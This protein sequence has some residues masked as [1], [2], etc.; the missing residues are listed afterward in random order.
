MKKIVFVF[1]LIVSLSVFAEKAAKSTTTTKRIEVQGHRGAR[2]K[3][4]ENSLPAFEYALGLGV[5]VLELDLGVSKDKKLVLAHDPYIN[6]EQ[7]LDKD[8]NKIKEKVLLYSLNLSEIKT[9]KCGTLPHPRFPEQKKMEVGYIT[10]DEVFEL[11]GASTLPSAKTVR[12][13]IETKLVPGY[14]QITPEPK[15][16]AELVITTLKKYKML[17]RTVLQSF[18]HRT[19]VEAR[20]LEPKIGLSPLL[21]NNFIDLNAMAKNLKAKIVSPNQMWINKEAVIRA[22]KEGIHVIPWT[23]NNKT[24]WERLIDL[25][26][27]GII[28]DYPEELIAFL[29]TKNLR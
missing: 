19:L 21:E 3:F 9:Y 13:N 16:F 26:V 4:P 18:D 7:C 27:D 20:K 2:D 11:V 6:E 23:A 8:G 17:N 5:D 29:K 12:F 25:G 15:E 14:P 28:S 24:E 1:V 10:L 22:Q